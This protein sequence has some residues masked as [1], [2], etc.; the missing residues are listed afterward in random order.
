[1]IV[2]HKFTIQK[3]T[4]G[5]VNVFNRLHLTFHFGRDSIKQ[6]YIW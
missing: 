5:N 4:K 2:I 6:S 3:Q 1:M